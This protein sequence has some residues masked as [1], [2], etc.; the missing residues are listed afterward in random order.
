MAKSSSVATGGSGVSLVY[1]VGMGLAGAS[2]WL[3]N[4]SI[5]WAIVHAMFSWW[6]LLYLCMGCGGGLPPQIF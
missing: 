3:L 5:G 4:H 2:S 6:Y 1:I